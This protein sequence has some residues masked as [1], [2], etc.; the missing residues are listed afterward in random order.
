MSWLNK[1]YSKFG[2]FGTK[3]KLLPAPCYI[4]IQPS[5]ATLAF[6]NTSVYEVYQCQYILPLV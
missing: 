3:A 4:Y 5:W 2:T 6:L 1:L